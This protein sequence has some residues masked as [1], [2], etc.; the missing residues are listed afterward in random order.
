M[1][2]HFKEIQDLNVKNENLFTLAEVKNQCLFKQELGKGFQTLTQIG[3]QEKKVYK[4]DCIIFFL[5][6][7]KTIVKKSKD[8]RQNW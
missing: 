3:R 6:L 4:F 7:M 1:R 8:N 5:N 2:K